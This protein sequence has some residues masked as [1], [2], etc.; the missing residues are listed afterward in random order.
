M[1]ATPRTFLSLALAAPGLLA[2]CAG[3]AQPGGKPIDPGTGNNM[4]AAVVTRIDYEEALRSAAIK[5]TGN[6][7]TLVEIKRV[8]DAA[9][10]SRAAEYEKLLDEY[11][12]RP[13]FGSQLLSFFRD[14]FKMG[15]SDMR[16]GTQVNF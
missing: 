2:A 14:T 7:P 4:Q 9:E 15:G 1:K 8:R 12:A 3:G 13:S 11:M 10:S 6:Y 5:L 16:G